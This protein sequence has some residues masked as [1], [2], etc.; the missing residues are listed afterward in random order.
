MQKSTK[1]VFSEFRLTKLLRWTNSL[2]IISK[3][4]FFHDEDTDSG[5][6]QRLKAVWIL[7]VWQSDSPK[8]RFRLA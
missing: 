1:S 7:Q 8:C 4:V 6:K 5:K 2:Q 3:I